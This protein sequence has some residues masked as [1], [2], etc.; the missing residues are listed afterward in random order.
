MLRRFVKR[1][2]RSMGLEIRRAPSQDLPFIHDLAVGDH[3]LRF[4]I[5]DEH[6]RSWWHKE[7]VAFDAELRMLC[8][9]CSPGAIALDV[10]AHHGFHTLMMALWAGPGGHVHA[11]E[12]NAENALVLQANVALNRLSHCTCLP[13]AVGSHTG[14][15][16]MEG[17]SVALG[18]G[19]RQVPMTSVDE[20]CEQAGLE[21]VDVLK[22]DVEGFEIEVLRGAAQALAKGAKLA[23]ELHPESMADYGSCLGDLGDLVDLGRY[24]AV[25]MVRPDWETL[26]PVQRLEELPKRGVINLFLEPRSAL[27]D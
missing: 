13:V 2:M 26:L 24:T 9:F 20:Y 4:W 19:C 10:G 14:T 11:F 1:S 21:R 15:A 22:I 17:Q 18:G 6:T 16:W 8:R 25:A 27:T 5:V 3:R 23:L 7:Q 12:P